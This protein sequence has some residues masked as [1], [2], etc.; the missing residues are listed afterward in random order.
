MRIHCVWMLGLQHKEPLQ[1]AL[2][3]PPPGVGVEQGQLVVAIQQVA[4]QVGAAIVALGGG[5]GEG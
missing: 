1:Q 3:V 5:A 4:A 2:Q